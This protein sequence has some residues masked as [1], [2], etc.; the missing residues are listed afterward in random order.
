VNEGLSAGA[1]RGLMI[2]M[3]A[4][5]RG[6]EDEDPAALRGRAPRIGEDRNRMTFARRVFRI[7]GI[8]GLIALVPMYFLENWI[9]RDQPPAITHPEY[10]YGFLGVAVAWQVAFL[11]IARDPAR[12]RPLMIPAVLEKA[13]F[14][15]A[16]IALF[17]A[18]RLPAATMGLGLIDLALGALF[19]ISYLRLGS[20]P[21]APA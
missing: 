14:G 13:S 12:F 19:A 3:D 18:G 8:Y 10:F 11:V 7:A 1:I 21:S 6:E 5:G 15:F 16:T 9:G 2:G 20:V 4:A 17:L